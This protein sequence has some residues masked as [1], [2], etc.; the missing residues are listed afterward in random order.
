MF[1]SNGGSPFHGSG[2]PL[3]KGSIPL[4]RAGGPLGGGRPLSGGGPLS[5]RKLPR[6]GGGRFLAKGD[7]GVWAIPTQ[8]CAVILIFEICIKDIRTW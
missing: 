6:G 4:G 8:L 1:S 7:I 3:G 5:G 2:R